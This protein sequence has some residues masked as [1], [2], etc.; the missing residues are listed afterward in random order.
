MEKRP[1]LDESQPDTATVE[2]PTFSVLQFCDLAGSE[3][4]KNTGH[5]ATQLKEAIHINGGLLS[6]GNVVSALAD[7]KRR[8][9]HVP[10]VTRVCI[11]VTFAYLVFLVCFAVISLLL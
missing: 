9:K 3:R 8:K 1:R 5:G 10:Y 2:S 4:T 7:K 11:G 6:L